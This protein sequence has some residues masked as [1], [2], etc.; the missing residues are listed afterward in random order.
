LKKNGKLKNTLIEL[1]KEFDQDAVIWIPIGGKNAEL[2]GTN[3]CPNG[4]PGFNKTKTFSG[5]YLGIKGDAFTKANDR[6]FVFKEGYIIENIT[7]PPKGFAAALGC[8]TYA[9]MN[10]QDIPVEDNNVI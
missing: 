4:F 2:I 3:E 9:K 6:P 8:S 10:W 1:G 5:T 7:M